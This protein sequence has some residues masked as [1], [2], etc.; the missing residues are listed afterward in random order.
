MISKEAKRLHDKDL[1][2]NENIWIMG[3]VVSGSQYQGF[4]LIRCIANN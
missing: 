2:D 4:Y 1:F 3:Y